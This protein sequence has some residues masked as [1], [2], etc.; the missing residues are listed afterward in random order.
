[1]S[2]L[3]RHREPALYGLDP[4]T[5][6]VD[7]EVLGEAIKEALLEAAAD[8]KAVVEKKKKDKPEAK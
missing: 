1:M 7:G 6:T 2:M 4:E 3:R 8:V 5:N